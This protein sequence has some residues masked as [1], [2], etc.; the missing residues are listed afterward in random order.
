MD[1][2]HPAPPLLFTPLALRG[3]TAR[4][5][6]V[7]SPMSQYQSV[8]GAPTDWHLVHLGKFAMGGAGI[9]FCEETAVEAESRKTYHCPGIYS[10]AQVRAWRRI[11][12]FLKAQGALPAMQLGHGGRKVA[13]KGPRDGFRPLTGDDAANG[14][15]PWRGYSASSVPTKPGAPVPIAMDRDDIAR[16]V[17]AHVDAARRT[18]EAGFEICE[19]HGAHGYLIQQFLS[20]IV[21]H[22]TDRYG[23]D[24]AGRMRFGLEVVEAVRKVWPQDRPLFFRVSSVDG[25]GGDGEDGH[26]STRSRWRASS[27]RAGSIWSIARRAA[28]TGR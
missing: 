2:N 24:L 3:V 28:S 12:D 26:W 23:G 13:T 9:V 21:N 22:R 17:R 19:I 15:P 11:T 8:D 4:N 18:L 16:I 1:A 27:R 25:V 5:R 6:V 7:V 10:D 20:P 14:E